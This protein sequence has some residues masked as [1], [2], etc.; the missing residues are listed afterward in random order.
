MEENS[1]AVTLVQVGVGP[2]LDIGR[3]FPCRVPPVTEELG[4]AALIGE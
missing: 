4:V 2:A 3:R 1:R